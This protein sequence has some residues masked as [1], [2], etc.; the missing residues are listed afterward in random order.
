MK[1]FF[2]SQDIKY[3]EPF[4]AVPLNTTITFRIETADV[5]G[6]VLRTWTEASG[7][8]RVEMM[9][10]GDYFVC[11]YTA[12]SEPCLLWYY[13]L[14]YKDGNQYFYGN[15]PENLGGEGQF[16]DWEPPSFQVTVYKPIETP[17]WFKRA[18]VYYIFPD[19]FNRGSDYEERKLAAKRPAKW[20]GP[21]QFFEK[22][23]NKRPTYEKNADGSIKRWQFFGGTLQGIV[24]KLP[25]IRSLGADAIYLCPIFKASSNHRYDTADYMSIDPLLGDEDSFRHLCKEAEKHRISIILDGVF[26]HT[27]SDSI[28][29]DKY[30]NFG[31]KGA[32]KNPKSPYYPWYKFN[33]D[34]TYESWW[35]DSNLPN[36]VE[37]EPSHEEFICGKNGVLNKWMDL[38]ARGWRLD[39]ADELPDDFIKSIR[40]TIKS[41]HDG[42]DTILIGEVWEDASNKV[43]YDVQRQ[44]ILGEELDSVMNY[45][46]RKYILEFLMK[47]CSA[48]DFCR[49]VM[50]IVENYPKEILLSVINM[51]G[52]HDRE[53]PLTLLSVGA[54][55]PDDLK[56]EYRLKG[57]DY[58][59]AKMRLLIASIMQYALPGVPVIYYGDEAGVEGHTD[60]YNRSTYP[61]GNED[62][63]I[64]LHYKKLGLIYKQHPSLQDGTFLVHPLGD[65]V[66]AI[67]RENAN[68]R[69]V[70]LINRNWQTPFV[71]S[72]DVGEAETAI[73][74]YSGEKH[75]ITDRSLF[76]KV[77]SAG[78]KIL[79]LD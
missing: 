41:R 79:L 22:S 63:D 67:E 33:E 61:W 69:I 18:I 1:V 30:K 9:R 3:K 39:V 45:P 59:L 74:L 25:Y 71:V 64:L 12:P 5:D 77:E 56:S 6:V 55:I 10:F 72:V 62:R 31:G 36:V 35:G 57:I 17:E 73:D 34:G 50:S 40:K 60:P 32:Y 75:E 58:E 70:V 43:S 15:N 37:Q 29:F 65:D 26:S 4:G 47:N 42:K 53:R 24:E 78:A 27:G 23:W 66:I 2:N 52:S 11:E 28:Y 44:F 7:E 8:D 38:G 20:K 19:R 51:L 14:I 13:F 68:E 54:D 21:G 46:F 76:L 16:S 49:K 48:E